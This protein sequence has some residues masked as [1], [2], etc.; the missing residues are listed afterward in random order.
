MTVTATKVSSLAWCRQPDSSGGLLF[1]S[2][3]TVL[4]S[5][6]GSTTTVVSTGLAAVSDSN[7]DFVGWVLECTDATNTQNIGL[8]RRVLKYVDATGACTTDPWPAATSDADQ[9]L[10]LKTPHAL[11]VARSAASATNGYI[12]TR[13]RDEATNTWVGA[14]QAGGFH[15]EPLSD[16]SVATNNAGDTRL[17]A[18]FTNSTQRIGFATDLDQAV[19]IGNAWELWKYPELLAAPIADLSLE[20]IE[21]PHVS[22]LH[23]RRSNANGNRGGSLSVELLLRGPGNGR[24]GL[25]SESHEVLSAVLTPT[26]SAGDSVASAGNTTSFTHSTDNHTTGLLGVTSNGDACMVTADSGT[27]YTLSPT[28]GTAVASGTKL[29]G[30]ATYKPPLDSSTSAWLNHALSMKGYVGKDLLAYM[31]GCVPAISF[32][33]AKGDFLKMTAAFQVADWIR[34]GGSGTVPARTMKPT[35]STVNPLKCGN[36]RV[37]LDNVSWGLKSLTFDLGL[38]IQPRVNLAAP[39]DTDGFAIVGDNPTGSLGVYYDA[40]TRK[41][42]DDFLNGKEVEMLAQFGGTPGNPGVFIL[43]GYRI[44]YTGATIADDAGQIG[45]TLPFQVVYSPS[46]ASGL[47]RY[48]I[49]LS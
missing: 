18:T 2:P 22:G 14:A 29:Y 46:M 40:S 35:L 1:D 34:I 43:Y 8:R 6:A 23:G 4:A 42:I 48:A 30:V 45:L 24:I 19:A 20:Q 44:R 13:D 47:S 27:V 12:A 11:A 3:R 31:F 28:L 37:V 17:V 10:L 49:G 41:S 33:A 39:N 15:L 38:D 36:G 21:R 16:T 26:L 32:N 9:F 7:D 25:A 5:G